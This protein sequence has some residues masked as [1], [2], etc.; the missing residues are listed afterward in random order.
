[1]ADE[2]RRRRFC[3][4][5]WTA[6]T[7]P[8]LVSHLRGSQRQTWRRAIAA[9]PPREQVAELGVVHQYPPYGCAPWLTLSR[10]DWI[11]SPSLSE[12]L[13]ERVFLDSGA[14][15]LDGT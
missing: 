1:M 8:D 2:R 6:R 11:P 10:T 7:G 4:K 5:R 9:H 3:S 12:T 15:F 13:S 14:L